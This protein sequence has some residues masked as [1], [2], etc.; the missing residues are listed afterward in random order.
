MALD[1]TASGPPLIYNKSTV[2]SNVTYIIILDKPL[3]AI[4]T[5]FYNII[6]K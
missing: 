3:D 2:M 1:Y 5:A 6:V 4:K